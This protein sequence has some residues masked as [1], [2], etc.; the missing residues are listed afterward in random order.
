LIIG[1][2]GI[3]TELLED[4]AVVPLPASGRRIE[5]ALRSLRGA[6]VLLG[7]RGRVAVDLAAA[8]ELA[9]RIGEL[10]LE[11]SLALIELNPAFV[12]ADG[13]IVADAKAVGL[14]TT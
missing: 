1:L 14:C 7:G 10:L 5:Q 13:A 2:G 9:S 4:V 3:W 8:C 6:P 12:S 11:R